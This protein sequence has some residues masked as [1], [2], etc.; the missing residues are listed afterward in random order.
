M[1]EFAREIVRA[2]KRVDYPY[3]V[4]AV[5]VR[6]LVFF[7]RDR[8]ARVGE[9]VAQPLVGTPI[10]VKFYLATADF[11]SGNTALIKRE[12]AQKFSRLSHCLFCR[13]QKRFNAGP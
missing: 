1:P 2:V 5:A 3:F 12:R 4:Q 10:R 13:T 6:S 11:C 8:N 9:Q 7:T